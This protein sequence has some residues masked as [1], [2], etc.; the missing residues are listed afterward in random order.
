M[1]VYKITIWPI[2]GELFEYP[3]IIRVLAKDETAAEDFLWK[4]G[5]YSS[6]LFIEVEKEFE[7]SN[8]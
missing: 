2:E 8:E 5:S 4:N 3:N 7:L 6:P 1:N